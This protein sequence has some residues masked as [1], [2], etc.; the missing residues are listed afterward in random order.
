MS[1]N[2]LSTGLLRYA[3]AVCALCLIF[4]R[5]LID[6]FRYGLNSSLYS[7]VLL[8]PLVSGWFVWQRRKSLTAVL[9]ED[10][11]NEGGLLRRLVVPGVVLLLVGLWVTID[12][13]QRD[14]L[15]NRNDHLSLMVFIF[16]TC[17]VLLQVL[18][19]GRA[20]FRAA[21]FPLLFLYFMMPIPGAV[22]HVVNVALQHATSFTLAGMLKLTG[23]P[24]FRDGFVFHLPG[25]TLAVAEECSGIRSTLVLL[26]TA[27]IG[28]I[29]FLKTPWRRSVLVASFFPIAALRNAARITT[30]A[31]LT[32]HVDPAYLHGPVHKQGGTPFFLLSLLP[33]FTIMIILRR[34][35]RVGIAAEDNCPKGGTTDGH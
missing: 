28:G 12:P 15:L 21:L 25:L 22:L 7:H 5:V 9:K 35:E 14:L 19:L 27:L 6:L 34:S 16:V 11:E 24:T 13:L 33:L 23:T 17:L 30:I 32:I 29:L 2:R 8:V 3:C 18:M 4:H 10:L 26:M 20:C 1:I 31:M